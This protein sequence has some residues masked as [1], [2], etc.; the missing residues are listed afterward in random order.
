MWFAELWLS[1]LERSLHMRQV[2]GSNP[3]SST[4]PKMMDKQ[5]STQYRDL[6][7][8]LTV[9]EMKARYKQSV[10]GYAWAILV[11]LVNLVVLS[12]IFSNLFRVPTG[13]IPY[14]IYLFIALVPWT[15]MTNAI[16]LATSS[17]L[18]NS[19]LITKVKLPREILPLTAIAARMVDL[20]LTSLILIIFL[21]I[22]QVKFQ[23]TMFYIPLIFLI[24]LMLMI[25]VS[26]F[27][28]ATNVFF[29]DVEHMLGVVLM[30]WMYMTPVVY[31]P[32][33]IPA[34]LELLFYANPM[35]AIINSYRETIL[36]GTAPSW[37]AFSYSVV[38]SMIV[39]VFG[40]F[41]FK[42]RAKSFAD[43]I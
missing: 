39:L 40:Y 29:R 18:A 1:W 23:P 41:Y 2:A 8:Q 5:K 34:N 35:T 11:P 31:S 33:L 43:V 37:G 9:R 12:V 4:L 36:F 30:V 13:N 38:S 26:F 42:R 21:I 15:F 10:L 27:L 19:A 28:S 14:P 32:Q 22:F 3:V 6:F 17:V 7:W 20:L 16:T 24:Q 25:G